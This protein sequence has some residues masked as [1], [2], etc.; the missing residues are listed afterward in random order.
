[1]GVKISK[2][3]FYKLQPKI[4]KLFLN[5]LHNGPHITSFV[6]FEILRL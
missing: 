4:F 5:F 3:Y 1:M 2:R 6:I